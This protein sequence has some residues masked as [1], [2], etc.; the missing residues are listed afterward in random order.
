MP[1]SKSAAREAHLEYLRLVHS[2]WERWHDVFGDAHNTAL[3]RLVMI[4]WMECRPCDITSLAVGLNVSRQQAARR[5]EQLASL[6]FVE[7]HRRRN[8]IVVLPKTRLIKMTEE[9]LPKRLTWTLSR[10]RKIVGLLGTAMLPLIAQPDEPAMREPT[11]VSAPMR[12]KAAVACR[13]RAGRQRA[14]PRRR[15]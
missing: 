2:H 1:N 10:W 12:N 13:R 15:R 6:G 8:H 3:A 11:E 9:E 7:Q 5:I 4:G 14:S